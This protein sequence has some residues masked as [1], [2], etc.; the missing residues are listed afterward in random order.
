[1]CSTIGNFLSITLQALRLKV[2]AVHV[3]FYQTLQHATFTVANYF[4]RV[5]VIYLNE[6]GFS[7]S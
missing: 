2:A 3:Q 6:A 7:P 5:F 4:D 1:M